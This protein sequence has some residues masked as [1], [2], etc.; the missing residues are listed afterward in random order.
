MGWGWFWAA[1]ALLV[2][3]LDWVAAAL[4]AAAV[5]ELGHCLAVWALGGKTDALTF[6][7]GG[8][9]I[10]AWGLGVPGA[11]AATLAGPLLGL[12][13]VLFFRVIP[14]TAVC[15][16][17]QSLY[18]LLPICPLDGGRALKLL[19]N[20]CCPDRAERVLF[21]TERTTLLLLV[22][23]GVAGLL[24]FSWGIL[25]LLTVFPVL[26]EKFLANRETTRYNMADH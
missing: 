26:K 7:F 6:H 1:L 12:L 22:C 13:P 10:Q 23:L 25:P 14:R 8:A 24:W 16:L 20:C 21:L 2:L 9:I 3:P 18:N 4:A 5:H 17:A 19:L 15:A 11:I